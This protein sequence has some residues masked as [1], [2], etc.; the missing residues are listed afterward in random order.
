[1]KL[2]KEPIDVDFSTKSTPLT[3]EEHKEISEFIKQS[4]AGNLAREKRRARQKT[5]KAA[6][7]V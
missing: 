4:K 7:A 2:F 1:M 5:A 3:E 6:H